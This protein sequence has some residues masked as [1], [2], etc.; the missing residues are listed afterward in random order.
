MSTGR[1]ES[2]DSLIL[3][4]GR[5]VQVRPFVLPD[6]ALLFDWSQ[7]ATDPHYLSLHVGVESRDTFGKWLDEFQNRNGTILMI[8]ERKTGRTIGYGCCYWIDPWNRASYVALYVV[9]EFRMRGHA[10]EAA[11]ILFDRV[12]QTLPLRRIYLEV[13]TSAT[14][15]LKHLALVGAQ[16]HGVTPGF[17]RT[18][19][20][21]DGLVLMS[22]D[23]TEGP[24]TRTASGF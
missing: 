10:I 2:V 23:V 6:T 19:L 24:R 15:L 4:D 9:P 18:E 5:Y 13:A 3:F 12:L 21:F 1:S 14:R 20:G 7:S 8:Q 22:M 16:T 17:L 11:L